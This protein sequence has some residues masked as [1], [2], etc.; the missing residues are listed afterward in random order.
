MGNEG[1]FVFPIDH[2]NP[3]CCKNPGHR[4]PGS[5]PKRFCRGALRKRNTHFT[6]LCYTPLSVQPMTTV[7][8]SRK[9]AREALGVLQCNW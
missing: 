1:G 6:E 7:Q 8:V 5:R 3:E 9:P 4:A 2:N